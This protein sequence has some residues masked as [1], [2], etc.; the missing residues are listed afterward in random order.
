MP[1]GN[2]TR[3]W[4]FWS[5]SLV[6]ISFLM[7]NN[8]L[9]KF[10]QHLMNLLD[11]KTLS[12]TL[13]HGMVNYCNIIFVRLMSRKIVAWKENLKAELIFS[14]YGF[15]FFYWGWIGKRRKLYP[16]ISSTLD[17]RGRDFWVIYFTRFTS[18]R[19]IISLT[20][21][22]RT[23]KLKWTSTVD[24]RD[25]HLLCLAVKK[26]NSIEWN[27]IFFNL[28]MFLLSFSF[29]IGNWIIFLFFTIHLA[30]TFLHNYI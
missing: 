26:G 13:C 11:G 24:G 12:M 21:C 19:R 4:E 23:W 29:S 28:F 6:M 3:T 14:F 30:N 25:I 10:H 17:C 7:L 18:D 15:L 5:D 22:K 2:F 9:F 27:L 1:N 8:I 16:R 20:M